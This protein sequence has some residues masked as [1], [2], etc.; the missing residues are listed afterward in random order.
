[1]RDFILRY[2]YYTFHSVNMTFHLKEMI[3]HGNRILCV[4]SFVCIHSVEVKAC[5]VYREY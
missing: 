2:Q 4:P 5:N 1:M 3:I